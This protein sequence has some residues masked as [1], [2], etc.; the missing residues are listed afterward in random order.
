LTAPPL[1]HGPAANGEVIVQPPGSGAPTASAAAGE[2]GL[3][4]GNAAVPTTLRT[5]KADWAHYAAWCA[6]AGFTPLPAD[7]AAVGAYLASLA[8]THAPG[9]IRR[10]LSAIG[11]MHCINDLPWNASH[12][13]IQGPLQGLLRTPGRPVQKEATVSLGRG[14]V[15]G[16][17]L[18]GRAVLM[19]IAFFCLLLFLGNFFWMLLKGAVVLSAFLYL[20]ARFSARGIGPSTPKAA[21]IK[22]TPPLALAFGA[23]H[24]P[25]F[26]LVAVGTLVAAFYIGSS[27]VAGLM[28]GLGVCLGVVLGVFLRARLLQWRL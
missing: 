11:K 6:Q 15:P 1:R 12:P 20:V 5:Y 28:L 9:T 7:P 26:R 8:E 10:R 21:C 14:S 22:A 23:V 27:G 18:E 2:A 3:S 16:L 25:A 19:G 17:S 24:R 4:A 13:A